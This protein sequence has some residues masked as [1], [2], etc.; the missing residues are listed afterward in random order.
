LN[1]YWEEFLEDV[2]WFLKPSQ[3]AKVGAPQP[4]GSWRPASADFARL[5]PELRRILR[6]AYVT[7]VAVGRRR[8]QLYTWTSDAGS[9]SWLSPTPWTDPPSFV[10]PDHQ[11]L[12]AS[13]GGIIERSNEPDWWILNHYDTLTV[14]AARRNATFLKYYAWAFEEAFLNI[15]IEMT[16][17]YSIAEEANFNI[18]LCHRTRG[19]VILFAADHHFDYVEVYPG[20]PEYSL[21]RLVGARSFRRWVNVIA[22]Q[23]RE[24]IGSPAPSMLKW[25]NR[26][27]EAQVKQ[28]SKGRQQNEI[29]SSH[30][31]N[32]AGV[33]APSRRTC[34]RP[35]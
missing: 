11:V 28:S 14:H 2:S 17:F 9:H 23:W 18:T 10:H 29:R 35:R 22:K 24:G 7:P 3:T 27:Q 25:S 5:F 15:P 20:C 13:F 16:E 32:R 31:S 21:Y 34:K 33:V 4:P 6:A 12:L 19:E 30:I 26:F 8:Y 1:Q